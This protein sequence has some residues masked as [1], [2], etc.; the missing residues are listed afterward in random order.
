MNN[1]D[2]IFAASSAQS[3]QTGPEQPFDANA[4]AEKK[5][6]ERKGVYELADKTAQEVTA[7]GGKFRSYLDVQARFGR[8]SATNALLIFAQMPLA[9]QLRDFDGWK[10]L[11]RLSRSRKRALPF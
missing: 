9:I 10:I 3:G 11:V 6:A 8:Y 4:W 2:D 7:D 1:F 5:Q